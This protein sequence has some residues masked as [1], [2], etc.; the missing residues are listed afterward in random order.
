MTVQHSSGALSTKTRAGAELLHPN[1]VFTDD[2][3][4]DMAIV[5][6]SCSACLQCG[7]VNGNFTI[8]E[9]D[10]L[11]GDKMSQKCLVP[12]ASCSLLPE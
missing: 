2:A 4:G 9:I 7:D 3:T 10:G 8:M 12:D 1:T 6:T 11:P 5:H